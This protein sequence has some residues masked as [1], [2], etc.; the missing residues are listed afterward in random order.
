MRKWTAAIRAKPGSFA[1]KADAT[2]G[3]AVHEPLRRQLRPVGAAQQALDLAPLT[4]GEA[5]VSALDQRRAAEQQALV[6]AGE[7]E[8][9]VAGFAQTPNLMDHEIRLLTQDR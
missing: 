1:F 9:A 8:I 3:K 7:A 2:V 4:H 6:G 5:S